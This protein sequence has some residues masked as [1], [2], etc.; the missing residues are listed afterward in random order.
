MAEDFEQ[1][2]SPLYTRLASEYAD[3]LSCESVEE[4][5]GYDVFVL[6]LQ[7]SPGGG[8][9]RLARLDGQANTLEW[10]P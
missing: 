9:R 8:R 2:G 5:P 7:T 4:W 6:D 1:G 3:W 10:L